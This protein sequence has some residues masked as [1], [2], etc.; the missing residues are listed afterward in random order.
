MD[1]ISADLEHRSFIRMM[2]NSSVQVRYANI[3]LVGTCHDLSATGMG[4]VL[5]Q[6]DLKVGDEVSLELRPG[7][8]GVLPLQ[9]TAKV[10]HCSP[11]ENGILLGVHFTKLR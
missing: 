9:A 4:I 6:A 8:P 2:I 1:V 5:E 7:R 3:E 10:V 11:H